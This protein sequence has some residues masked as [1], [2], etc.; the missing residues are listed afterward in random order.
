MESLSNESHM[1]RTAVISLT[2]AILTVISFC[3][4]ALPI[5]FT[6]YICFPSS[7]AL[8]LIALGTGLISLMQIRSRGENGR[9]L[10]WIGS[11]VGG[12][13]AVVLLCLL[14]AGILLF[15]EIFRWAHSFLKVQ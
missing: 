9:A 11:L 10:A 6:G 3:G 4:G 13:T 12:F 15:P 14:L 2:A 1:N 5:P 7:A 8:G